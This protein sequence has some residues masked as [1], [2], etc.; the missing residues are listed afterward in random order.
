[1]IHGTD[2]S[3][4][5]V[6]S[7]FPFAGSEPSTSSESHTGQALS[8]LYTPDNRRDLEEPGLTR[9]R[10]EPSLRAASTAG[11]GWVDEEMCADHKELG[12]HRPDMPDERVMVDRVGMTLGGGY[13]FDVGESLEDLNMGGGSVLS[14][15]VTGEQSNGLSRCRSC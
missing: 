7:A 8:I 13:R 6:E 1:M 3:S 15:K 12:R 14:L 4:M 11:T 9:T 2:P 10:A 5:H